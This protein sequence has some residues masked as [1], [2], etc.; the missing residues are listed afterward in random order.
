MRSFGLHLRTG[1]DTE[2]NWV[3]FAILA[4]MAILAI[5]SVPQV[6]K[7]APNQP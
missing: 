1:Y 6:L 2:K 5:P 4:V 7:I 3:N